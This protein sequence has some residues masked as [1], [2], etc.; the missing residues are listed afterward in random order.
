MS[1]TPDL[2]KIQSAIYN[3]YHTDNVKVFYNKD[4]AW[5]IPGEVCGTGHRVQVEPYYTIIKL[6]GEE[7]AEFVPMSSFTPIRKDNMVA[8]LAD[9]SDGDNYGELLLYK[10]PKE[11]LVYGPLQ[12]EAKFDQDAVISQ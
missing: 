5:Q 3:T 1:D 8:W 2:F 12:I 7:K 4:G 9:R 11:K 10:F 6:P